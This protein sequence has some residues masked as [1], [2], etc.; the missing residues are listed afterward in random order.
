MSTRSFVKPLQVEQKDNYGNAS[1]RVAV[2]ILIAFT[3]DENIFTIERFKS[4]YCGINRT[5]FFNWQ[6]ITKICHK[7][8]RGTFEEGNGELSNA[9]AI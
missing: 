5:S 9:I 4:R 1:L 8:V 7:Q 6:I 3:T 2:P